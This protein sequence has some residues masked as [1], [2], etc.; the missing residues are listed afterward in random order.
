[1]PLYLLPNLLT[2]TSDPKHCL[3]GLCFEIVPKLDGLICESEK[4]GRAYLKLFPFPNGRTFKDIPLYEL[5][6]H[7]NIK[8]LTDAL[9]PKMTQ[10]TWGLISDC[11]LP[12]FADPG[13]ALVAAAKGA[14]IQVI[15][16]AGPS[17]IVLGLMLS[18][19]PTQQFSFHG[20]LPREERALAFRLQE[21]EARSSREG[22]THLF[23]EAP[24]RNLK[25]FNTLCTT[26]KGSTK[27]CLASNLTAP[28][29]WVHTA[30]IS[31][32]KRSPPPPI[33]KIPTLFL[34]HS[35]QTLN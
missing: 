2:E 27:L 35:P 33:D 7:T 20:Y 16:L 11:G 3:P 24:Y 18:G 31:V 29:E 28:D 19:L 26:L 12:L 5:S 14:N 4:R 22:A 15:A 25:L 8:E 9:L 32:W 10:L 34:F 21:L 23:I 30:P 6:E 17:S 13:S 1:M